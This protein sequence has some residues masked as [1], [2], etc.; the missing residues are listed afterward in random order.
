MRQSVKAGTWA[1]RTIA[2]A[3]DPWPAASS[4][5]AADAP[6]MSSRSVHPSFGCAAL[7]CKIPMWHTWC[8]CS[9]FEVSK[10]RLPQ[11]LNAR[12]GAV[13]QGSKKEDISFRTENNETHL[14]RV[15]HLQGG[16]QGVVRHNETAS[17]SHPCHFESSLRA[18]GATRFQASAVPVKKNFNTPQQVLRP[19]TP[20]R[21]YG[22]LTASMGWERAKRPRVGS[23]RETVSGSRCR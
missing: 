20:G 23:A 11:R 4:M 18:L 6:D 8:A 5:S 22:W 7:C 14:R 17:S 10:E 3:A 19:A 12:D 1:Y 16:P 2:L 9:I 13:A 21:L 15:D